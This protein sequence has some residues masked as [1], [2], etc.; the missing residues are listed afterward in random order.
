MSDSA[1]RGWPSLTYWI[2]SLSHTKRLSIDLMC[3]ICQSIQKASVCIVDITTWN[4]NVM[5]ELGLMYGWG[6][7]VILI[8]HREEKTEKADLK[9]MQFIPYDID[10]YPG[11]QENL[12]VVLQTMGINSRRVQPVARAGF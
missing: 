7:P 9:G 5:F 12:T 6:K 3:K 11:L 8:K 2:G 10:D 4:A 1:G